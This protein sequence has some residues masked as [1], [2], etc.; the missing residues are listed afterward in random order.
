[1]KRNKYFKKRDKVLNVRSSTPL[2]QELENI[3]SDMLK[4]TSELD[5]L[6]QSVINLNHKKVD[7]DAFATRK[8]DKIRKQ[9]GKTQT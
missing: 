4:L 8:E 1:M 6:K 3:K 9:G 5:D 7:K 2:L